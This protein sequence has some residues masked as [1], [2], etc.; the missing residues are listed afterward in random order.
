MK[1]NLPARSKLLIKVV[2]N[3]VIFSFKPIAR[4]GHT[5]TH[6]HKLVISRDERG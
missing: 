2:A 3:I 5:V 6:I 1:S 4:A